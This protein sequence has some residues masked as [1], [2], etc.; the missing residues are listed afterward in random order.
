MVIMLVI[1]SGSL[2]SCLGT[3]RGSYNSVAM[4]LRA[5]AA[6]TKQLQ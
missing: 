4:A 3:F 6:H 2:P 1:T 5:D